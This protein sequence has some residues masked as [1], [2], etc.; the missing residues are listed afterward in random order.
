MVWSK[1]A[2]VK[3]A[4]PAATNLF[5]NIELTD[6]DIAEA[7][8]V[9]NT[10]GKFIRPFPIDIYNKDGEICVSVIIEVYVRNLNFI[11]TTI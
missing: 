1:S 2:T 10:G 5:F 6:S 11:D 8:H 7:E 9:L 3:Y 4:K